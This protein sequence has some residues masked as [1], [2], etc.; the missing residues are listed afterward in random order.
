[1]SEHLRQAIVCVRNVSGD[2]VGTGFLVAHDKIVTCSHVVAAALDP[3]QDPRMQLTGRVAIDFPEF[4]SADPLYAKIAF[5]IPL[6]KDERGD[7]TG[8]VL[9]GD[10]PPGT[11]SITLVPGG[12]QLWGIEFRTIGFTKSSPGGIWAFGK[13]RDVQ[14]RGWLQMETTAGPHIQYGYSGAPVWAEEVN[15]VV[16]MV[17]AFMAADR[18]P[19]DRVA[20]CIPSEILMAA[21]PDVLK[22]LPYRGLASFREEDR[23]IFFGRGDVVDRLADLMHDHALILIHGQSGC[24][25]SSVVAAGLA[26]KAST[27]GWLVVHMHPGH[28]PSREMAHCL[29]QAIE[30]QLTISAVMSEQENLADRIRR[31]QL[32][33]VLTEA[34]RRGGQVSLLLVIDQF[35][36]VFTQCDDSSDR[37]A[38]L[39]GLAQVSSENK[40]RMPPLRI[41]VAMRTNFLSQ[42][43]DHATFTDA[44]NRQGASVLIGAMTREQLREAVE[45]PAQARRVT[46]ESGLVER[47]LEEVSEGAGQLPLLEELLRQLW[48]LRQGSSL[49]HAAYDELGGVKYALSRHAKQ[50]YA[51][52][53]TVEQKHAQAILTKLV[54]LGKGV[55]DTRQI[56][57]RSEFSSGDWSLVQHLASERLLVTDRDRTGE[58][59]V[60]LIHEALI[61]NWDQLS[62]WVNQGREFLA[63]RERT[64]YTTRLWETEGYDKD[65]LLRGRLAEQAIASC[66]DHQEDVDDGI[67][68]FAI[69]SYTSDLRSKND[70]VQGSSQYAQVRRAFSQATQISETIS[71]AELHAATFLRIL[72]AEFRV[73]IPWFPM[74]A[75]RRWREIRSLR[76]KLSAKDAKLIPKLNDSDPI[77]LLAEIAMLILFGWGISVLLTIGVISSRGYL[78][79]VEPIVTVAV[80]MVVIWRINRSLPAALLAAPALAV[81][82]ETVVGIIVHVH[83]LTGDSLYT[84]T[85]S[86]L[87]LVFLLEYPRIRR[88]SQT[89]AEAALSS[90]SDDGLK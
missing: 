35:E 17:V 24:G 60:Q 8:L 46:L 9:E 48:D 89:K 58:Q 44:L 39:A 71:D 76:P 16:G 61:R 22:P 77:G 2:V 82:A 78:G 34:Q 67:K 11:E 87:L 64:A 45:G 32:V 7:I 38:F 13:L 65:L 70:P 62:E 81:I 75:L 14:G 42:A 72:L 6:E 19:D 68:D 28:S 33:S 52:L 56:A 66:L 63:W 27:D 85:P 5:C 31:G 26:S 53:S 83:G 20:F 74:Q 55:P 40:D 88:R 41:V 79:R 84:F 15:G 10:P 4:P 25:K 12:N 23:E 3:P 18:T 47:I 37:N 59:T 36:E 69:R 86:L 29:V 57:Y 1:M 43:S 30:P 49:T 54:G 90:P 73:L 50:V 51:K 21:W 80:A